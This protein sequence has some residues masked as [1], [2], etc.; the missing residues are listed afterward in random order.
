M[1]GQQAIALLSHVGRE[2]LDIGASCIL[3]ANYIP[4]Y[5]PADLAPLLE[6]ANG[7]QVHCSIPD[8]LVLQRYRARAAQGERH[9]VHVDE[10]AEEELIER[11]ASGGGRALPVAA[12]LL[13][14][15]STDGFNPGIEEIAAFCRS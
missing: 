3:E 15:D 10:G 1:I 11:I 7:R 12:D 8:E 6:L 13:E 14:V 5:A 2:L 4:E 9:P